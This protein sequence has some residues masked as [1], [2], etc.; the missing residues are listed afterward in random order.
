MK[1]TLFL[2][3][4]ILSVAFLYAQNFNQHRSE[5]LYQIH[6][7][8]DIDLPDTPELSP[9]ADCLSP[10]TLSGTFS[11][12]C[13]TINLK[14]Y[15]PTE[16]LWDNTAT[17]NTG[18][19][20]MR[21]MMETLSHLTIADDFMVPAG[22]TWVISE[23]FMYGFYNTQTGNYI[24]PDFIGVE[25]WEDGGNEV[26]G[27][28][29]LEEPFLMPISG[30]VEGQ[31]TIIL[32]EPLTITG[33]AKLWLSVYGT[34][35][36]D[37]DDDQRFFVVSH[38]T[39]KGSRFAQWNEESGPDWVPFIGSDESYCSLFFKIQGRKTSAPILYNV[40]R[41]DTQ[42]ASNISETNYIDNGFD[43]TIKTK[44]SVT[45]VCPNGTE[46]SRLSVTKQPC[47]PQTINENEIG[48]FTIV[49]NP[50]TDKITITAKSNFSKIE[51]INFLG[52]TVIS[53]SNLNS[54]TT[55]DVAHLNSGVYFVRIASETGTFVQ[56]FV[57]Q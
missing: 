45:A 15:A 31:N 39:P 10:K 49:P 3:G 57:K 25:I 16:V 38:Q 7:A 44:W 29:I 55:L 6:D 26:P 19:M 5:Y 1:K 12:D 37:F 23:V 48:S 47:K 14:W 4:L 8:G 53:Q 43:Y 40:Y 52:Q 17:S 46:S 51:V 32:P 30:K 56:K 28:Q 27:N 24:S 54:A 2:L 20:S 33:P 21:W 42:I 36:Q 9:F 35:E 34:Y 22:E 50:A 41:E 11:P 13:K 18:Y